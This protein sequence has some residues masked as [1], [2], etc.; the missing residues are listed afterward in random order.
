MAKV[1]FLSLSLFLSL[2]PSSSSFRS[3]LRAQDAGEAEKV[4][5]NEGEWLGEP[6][7]P[8]SLYFYSS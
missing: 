2:S 6:K 5:Q 7:H 8:L 1:P 3:W 4:K